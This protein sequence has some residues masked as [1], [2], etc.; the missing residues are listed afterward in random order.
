MV[1]VVQ[2]PPRGDTP[3]GQ[4]K[5]FA[6][7][8][9]SH[10]DAQKA[11]GFHRDLEQY[12]VPKQL[13]GTQGRDGLI[14][15][16]L[17][18]I[19]RDREELASSSD[20]SSAIRDA[21]S[22]SACL[23]VLCSPAAAK[24]R[25]VNEE[26]L[27]FRRLGRHD[28]IF[29]VVVSGEPNAKEPDQECF[30]PALRITEALGE[31]HPPSGTEPIAAD[32]RLDGDGK[33]D[34]K[35]KVIAGLVGIPLNDLRRREV[36][37]ARRRAR[38]FQGIASAMLV[39][40]LSAIAGGWIAYRNMQQAD[41]RFDLAMNIASG[42]VDRAV[43][44]SDKY[45]VPEK[46]IG[47]LLSWADQ[48]FGALSRE[49]LSDA[50]EYHRANLLIALSDNY[51]V[52]NRA[53]DQLRVAH[54]ARDMLAR[55][56]EA[57]PDV[58]QWQQRLSMA[59]DRVGMAHV[60]L[61]N[62][63]DALAAQREALALN[64][65][66]LAKL[67]ADRARLRAVAISHERI[68]T[69]LALQGSVHEALAAQETSLSLSK[70]IAEELSDLTAQRDL[71]ISREKIGEL[72]GRLGKDEEALAQH[73]AALFI[74]HNVAKRAPDNSR[75]QRDLEVSYNKVGQ[76]LL[77]R[78][79]ARG[80]FDAHNE[81]LG[82]AK[83]LAESD[84]A[85]A[86]WLHDLAATRLGLGDALDKLNRS[87]DALQEYQ[88]SQ[89]LADRLVHDNPRAA[90]YRFALAG[91]LERVGDIQS[92]L[93]HHEAALFSYSR[94]RLILT[95]LVKEDPTSSEWQ[96]DL[97]IAYVK[98][99]DELRATGSD[100]RTVRDSYSNA[101]ALVRRMADAGRLDDADAWMVKSL[102]QRVASLNA[103]RVDSPR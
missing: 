27:A 12:R 77:G 70:R 74:R 42:V 25:W 8:S 50:L 46:V 102:E 4:F 89:T 29:P 10:R 66:L 64:V 14:P 95:D 11:S 53:T 71:A 44:M 37:A 83:T 41:R 52:A 45:G 21:L 72:L 51:I 55:L 99:G 100:A 84:P 56:V 82:I 34:S 43:A 35:L 28:R 33:E 6:F 61:G 26:I 2:P 13:V 18:P 39:L 7:L 97:A 98:V 96:R 67:P 81:A 73:R 31:G 80:A 5:Y 48:S 87:A 69:A 94:K 19:F 32:M 78:D 38:I 15:K 47:D 22:R 103:Q 85:N 65:R 88:T 91:A 36:I 49:R 57:H 16:R 1:Q 9:Y 63:K 101:L 76:M 40:A 24:S 58:D 54:E 90:I 86:E 93:G 20:L 17:F 3:E 23:V 60:A 62:L 59:Y 79:D 68:G 75:L 92:R 30:P